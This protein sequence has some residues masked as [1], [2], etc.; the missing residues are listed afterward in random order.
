MTLTLPA[1]CSAQRRQLRA[2]Q[3]L[4]RR[5]DCRLDVLVAHDALE[6]LEEPRQ[7]REHAAGRS[8]DSVLGSIPS[9]GS[10]ET[11]DHAGT[12]GPLG[13][14]PRDIRSQVGIRTH[15]DGAGQVPGSSVASRLAY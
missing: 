11:P 3:L 7:Q 8:A 15:G 13:Q 4:L 14:R 2:A 6:P 1:I 10:A 9:A 5:V 12:E